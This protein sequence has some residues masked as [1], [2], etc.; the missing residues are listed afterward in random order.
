MHLSS[1]FSSRPGINLHTHISMYLPYRGSYYF[2]IFH[3]H[4]YFPHTQER[5][6]GYISA[7]DDNPNKRHRHSGHHMATSK[8]HTTQSATQTEPTSDNHLSSTT[9]DDPQTLRRKFTTR[10]TQPAAT[11]RSPLDHAWKHHIYTQ[12]EQT[13]PDDTHTSFTN[14]QPSR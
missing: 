6:T 1:A 3:S 11:L 8:P 2:D 13:Q 9:H 4:M 10:R 5:W 12:T 7:I 14:R